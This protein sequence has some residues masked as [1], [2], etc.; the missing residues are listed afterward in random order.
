MR[1]IANATGMSQHLLD[2]L[3]LYR[4]VAFSRV[5]DCACEGW[6]FEQTRLSTSTFVSYWHSNG[7]LSWNGKKRRQDHRLTFSATEIL[8]QR[9]LIHLNLL[10]KP[11]ITSNPVKSLASQPNQ[12]LSHE[13]AFITIMSPTLL[14]CNISKDFNQP[15]KYHFQTPKPRHSAI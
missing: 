5:W 8:D 4:L 14:P 15:E 7:V 13:F 9:I 6:S 10:V 3:V 1:R 2:V 12:D 11:Q